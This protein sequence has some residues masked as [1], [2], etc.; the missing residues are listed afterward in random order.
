MV[1]PSQPWPKRAEGKGVTHDAFQLQW[2][3]ILEDLFASD[4]V[5]VLGGNNFR[6]YREVAKIVQRVP[7]YPSP[8]FP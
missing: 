8:S 5:N 7:I 4:L 1:T 6:I 3:S 2:L